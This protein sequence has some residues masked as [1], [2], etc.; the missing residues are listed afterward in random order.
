[1]EIDE[2]IQNSVEESALESPFLPLEFEVRIPD[3][4]F[5]LMQRERKE[6]PKSKRSV[7]KFKLDDLQYTITV[8]SDLDPD[9]W[10]PALRSDTLH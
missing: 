5:A 4:A 1:M 7:L 10:L 3:D 8:R 6:P 2:I 9:D